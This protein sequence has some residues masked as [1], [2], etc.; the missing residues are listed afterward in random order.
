MQ[1]YLI[2]FVNGL[3]PN[4]G[5]T[6]PKWPQYTLDTKELLMFSDDIWSAHISLTTDNFRESAIDLVGQMSLEM[7][8]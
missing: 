5:S 7:P 2:H 4:A 1:D 8:L 6:L 3:D